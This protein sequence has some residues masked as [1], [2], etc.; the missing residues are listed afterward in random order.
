MG[1]IHIEG[2][3]FY[4]Y[5]GFYSAEQLIGNRYLCDLSF[6]CDFEQATQSDEL[7]GTI[8]YQAV[9][10]LIK[11]EMMVKSKLLEHVAGRIV[12]ALKQTY[13]GIENI[14]LKL[15]KLRP[16]INGVVDKISVV[17]KA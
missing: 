12:N 16:P 17:L 8:D 7:E 5:H 9:Y 14:E 13:P 3:E 1:Q 6:Y 2:M 15:S 11:K 10:E 4:A